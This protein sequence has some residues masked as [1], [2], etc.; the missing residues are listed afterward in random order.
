VRFDN[1]AERA[2]NVYK[3]LEALKGEDIA[4]IASFIVQQPRH[5]NIQSIVLTPTQQATATI[6]SRK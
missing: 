1:D 6:V 3:G 5:V 4:R 2:A